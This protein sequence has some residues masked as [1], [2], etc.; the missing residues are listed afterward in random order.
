MKQLPRWFALLS[1]S[2]A[3]LACA[4]AP[5]ASATRLLA[6]ESFQICPANLAQGPQTI[7][8]SAAWQSLLQSSGASAPY[9]KWQPDFGKHLVWAYVM[10]QQRSGGYA[11]RVQDAKAAATPGSLEVSLVQQSPAPGSL[12]SAQITSPC[13]L[14]M[15][16]AQGARSVQWVNAK[17]P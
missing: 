15:L 1:V 3:L 4:A 9:A 14:V 11:V 16:D 7:A 12:S 5:G 2:A 6:Q 17:A 10:G 8:S 13:V